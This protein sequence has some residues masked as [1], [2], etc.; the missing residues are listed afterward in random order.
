LAGIV[1][2]KLVEGGRKVASFTFVRVSSKRDTS[3]PTANLAT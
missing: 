1:T 2:L 3:R